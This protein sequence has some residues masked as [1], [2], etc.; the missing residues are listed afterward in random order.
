MQAITAIIH[1]VGQDVH[2]DILISL[3]PF[4]IPHEFV[5]IL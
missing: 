3:L 5:G 4:I 2:T 1:V